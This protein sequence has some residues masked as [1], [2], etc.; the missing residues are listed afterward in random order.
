MTCPYATTAPPYNSECTKLHPTQTVLQKLQ[1]QIAAQKGLERSTS[2][3]SKKKQI[4]N[5]L[6]DDIV[7]CYA[8]YAW[9][10]AP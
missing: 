9:T 5:Y 10:L 1:A 3:C 6:V 8:L 4:K 2:Y 7:V